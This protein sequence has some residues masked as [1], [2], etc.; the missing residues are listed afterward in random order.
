MIGLK[1]ILRSMPATALLLALI[2]IVPQLNAQPGPPESLFAALDPN[3]PEP[4]ISAEA[5][6][7]DDGEWVLYLDVEHFA[8]SE[9]CQ[10]VDAG[11]PVGHAH[12]YRGNTKVAAAYQPILSLG[13]L[14]PGEHSFRIM[15]RAQDHRA[16]VGASGLI[17]GWVNITIS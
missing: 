2:A 6:E 11:E 1:T 14:S 10:T 9:I 7:T 5:V 16:L 17:E 8:F 13:R 4:Q 15:L 3:L 12:V